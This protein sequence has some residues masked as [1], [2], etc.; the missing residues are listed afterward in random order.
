MDFCE[1]A[2][3]HKAHSKR[4]LDNLGI[5]INLSDMP[6][7]KEYVKYYL[8]RNRLV[9]WYLRTFKWAYVSELQFNVRVALLNK[10]IARGV[11]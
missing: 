11:E 4:I 3:N 2:E 9:R 5:K 6:E 10:V 8:G 7:H 1:I